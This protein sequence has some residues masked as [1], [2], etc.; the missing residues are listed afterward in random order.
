MVSTLVRVL[1]SFCEDRVPTSNVFCGGVL[2]WKLLNE[3]DRSARIS[4][5]L[6]TVYKLEM[7]GMGEIKSTWVLC[8][9]PGK[10]RP[11]DQLD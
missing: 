6:L 1:K 11:V 9:V 5:C 4:P 2:P 8:R 7:R 10:H 3:S